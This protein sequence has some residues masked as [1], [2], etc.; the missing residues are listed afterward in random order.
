MLYQLSYAHHR[1]AILY[2][3]GC[4][5]GF[6]F[7]GTGLAQLRLKFHTRTIG[8]V[9][10]A[11][12]N[13]AVPDCR[14]GEPFAKIWQ[15]R[16]DKKRNQRSCDRAQHRQFINDDPVGPGRNDGHSAGGQW[17]RHLRKAGEPETEERSDHA[18]EGSEEK[19]ARL[20]NARRK[21]HSH[22]R[23]PP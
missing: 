2:Q 16:G 15:A 12:E 19:D 20:A 4:L 18:A 9:G 23:A 11:H 5:R 6:H 22:R 21:N 8:R 13:L 14:I 10:D 17:I 7:D 1:L 3:L